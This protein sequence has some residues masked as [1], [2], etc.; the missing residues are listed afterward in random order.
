MRFLLGIFTLCVSWSVSAAEL[1]FNF[2]E[3]SAGGLPEGFRAVLAGKG[4]APEWK[5]VTADAPTEFAPLTPGAPAASQVS[6]LAQKSVDMTDERFPICIYE[7]ES[8][9]DFTFST[10][11]KIVSG[12]MEQ[13][14][15]L[16]FRFQNSSNFY[17]V[18]VSAAGRN[19]RFY[20]VVNGI[21]SEPIG[22]SMIIRPGNWHKLAV[23]CEG[24]QISI[25][26]DDRPAMP[27]L[28]DN[29][30]AEGQVGFWTKSDSVSYFTDALLNY[31][32]RVPVA[33]QLI[34]SVL[35]KQ[36]RLV[37]LRIYTLQP[38]KTTRIIASKDRSEI[39]QPGTDAEREAIVND[40]QSFSRANGI[41]EVTLPLRDRNGENIAAIR[42]RSESFFGETQNNAVTRA[43]MIRKMLEANGTSAA[44]LGR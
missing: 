8:F 15:G 36:S 30:F 18:R 21:R 38:D 11:F 1:R 41:N 37:G 5:I 23:Q 24:N 10:R 12:I 33:Q 26:L 13:M 19:L 29:T 28:T 4:P 40:V 32:P 44:D 27:K 42:V 34:D 35:E 6:V 17:V 43:M 9:R 25:F 2:S 39:G 20:K 3:T 7:K 31:T 14:A 16:V 22:P